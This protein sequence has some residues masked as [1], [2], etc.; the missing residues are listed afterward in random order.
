MKFGYFTKG[1]FIL[2]GSL[3]FSFSNAFS[4]GVEIEMEGLSPA[5]VNALQR[6]SEVREQVKGDLNEPLERLTALKETYQN[7]CGSGNPTDSG[8]QQQFNQ[9]IDAHTEVMQKISDF[10]SKYTEN[11]KVVIDELEPQMEQIAYDN[12]LSDINEDLIKKF[13]NNDHTVNDEFIDAI[14]NAFGLGQGQTLFEAK[15]RSYLDYKTELRGYSRLNNA[16]IA[17]IRTAQ[18]LQI[19]G[20]ILNPETQKGLA[21]LTKW[22]YGRQKGVQPRQVSQ[23]RTVVLR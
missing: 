15:S 5:A 13:E 10:T 14:V 23:S 21:T 20:P 1:L 7:S 17:K 6:M 18:R 8:C 11:L 9:I 12:S 2:V 19:I 3:L 16:L 4:Q 22:I